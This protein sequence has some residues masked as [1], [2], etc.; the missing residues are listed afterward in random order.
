[1]IGP[2]FRHNWYA[3]A[4][5]NLL[6]IPLKFLFWKRYESSTMG[7]STCAPGQPHRGRAVSFCSSSFLPLIASLNHVTAGIETF[8]WLTPRFCGVH[9]QIVYYGVAFFMRP[10]CCHL[11]TKLAIIF[12]TS[13]Y[14][15]IGHFFGHSI[16]TLIDCFLLHSLTQ[17]TVIKNAK[18]VIISIRLFSRAKS[19][20]D[21]KRWSG[22]RAFS[23]ST[24]LFVCEKLSNW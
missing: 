13:F 23:S 24:N 9:I 15:W 22:A 12:F 6:L 18:F 3:I 21:K 11:V 10:T 14:L 16:L 20:G 5:S 17:I 19:T 4:P 7:L 2:V 1:M 8:T